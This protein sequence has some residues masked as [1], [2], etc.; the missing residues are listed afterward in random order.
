MKKSFTA[1]S[2]TN[3]EFCRAEYLDKK[4]V[5]IRPTLTSYDIMILKAF[6]FVTGM[7][8]ELSEPER[9]ALIIDD[10]KDVGYMVQKGNKGLFLYSNKNKQKLYIDF[11]AILKKLLKESS[12][13]ETLDKLSGYLSEG[14]LKAEQQGNELVFLYHGKKSQASSA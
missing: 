7:R 11:N 4:Y 14:I 13:Q 10:E 1:H 3:Q 5:L 6:A 9:K 12:L 8:S 2:Y